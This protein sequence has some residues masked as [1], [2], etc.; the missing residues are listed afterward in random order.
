MLSNNRYYLVHNDTQTRHSPS[1]AEELV[2]FIRL[3]GEALAIALQHR[4]ADVA[5]G[6]DAGAV[7]PARG[8]HS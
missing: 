7:I 6:T 5:Q 2:G 4:G 8:E 1:S 3:D